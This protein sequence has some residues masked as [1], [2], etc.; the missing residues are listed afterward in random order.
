MKPIKLTGVPQTMNLHIEQ[1]ATE[2]FQP[3]IKDFAYEEISGNT[4]HEGIGPIWYWVGRYMERQSDDCPSFWNIYTNST[5][6]T[7]AIE[8]R[9][10]GDLQYKECRRILV[11][12]WKPGL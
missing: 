2:G 4:V 9:R 5:A 12:N 7:L 6:N 8:W 10:E 11:Q 1:L 3:L